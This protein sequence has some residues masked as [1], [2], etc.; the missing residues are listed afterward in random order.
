[1]LFNFKNN[2]IKKTSFL[3]YKK[4]VLHSRNKIFY[5]HLK[6]ADTLDGRFDLIVLHFFFIHSVLFKKDILKKKN[7]DQ[8]MDIMYKDFDSNL[9]EI[10][11]GDLSVGKKIYQMSEAIAGR[12]SAYSKAQ[13]N[14]ELLYK[15]LSRNIYGLNK[16]IDKKTKSIMVEYFLINLKNIKSKNL[17]DIKENSDIF[18]DLN[19]FINIYKR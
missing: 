6:V 17:S 18:F 3:I 15:T 14:K 5:T 11:V 19:K 10:G 7:Y 9:R 2:K 1:M 13:D 12:V 4:I 8:L 16:N